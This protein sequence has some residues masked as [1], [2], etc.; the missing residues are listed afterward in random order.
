MKVDKN[1]KFL[2]YTFLSEINPEIN[3]VF[4][5]LSFHVF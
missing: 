2:E 5:L 3:A 1:A 4:V